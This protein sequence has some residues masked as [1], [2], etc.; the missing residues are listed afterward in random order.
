VA[1]RWNCR[2]P[3]L[4]RAVGA[5]RASECASGLHAEGLAQVERALVTAAEGGEHAYLSR[6]H[7]TRGALLLHLRGTADPEVEASL[8]EAL[9]VAREQD[10]KDWAI[11]AATDLARLWAEQGRRAEACDVLAPVYYWFTEGFDTPDLKVAKA[12]LEELK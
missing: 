10:A 1:A 5:G 8:N 6:L 2:E 12:L 4:G 7:R 3:H 9:A 11:G